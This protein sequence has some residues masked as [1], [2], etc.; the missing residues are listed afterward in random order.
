M[1]MSSP[2]LLY[3]M[4]HYIQA[5]QLQDACIQLHVE[6]TG[7]K[8]KVNNRTRFIRNPDYSNMCSVL[9]NVRV[10]ESSAFTN[11]LVKHTH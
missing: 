4:T 5:T 3:I 10:N 1:K 9:V 7:T 6:F 2:L 8:I 11:I